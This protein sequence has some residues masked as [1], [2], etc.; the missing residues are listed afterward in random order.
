MDEIFG[1]LHHKGISREGLE[2][3]M[4]SMVVHPDMEA[5]CRLISSRP[6]TDCFVLS[7]SNTVF[8]D[9]IL[10]HYKLAD[11][12]QRVVTNPAEFD[13]QGRLHVQH[14]H[15][16]SCC[17]CPQNLC[18]GHFLDQFRAAKKYDKVV[19]IGDGGGDVCPSLRLSDRD[20]V[21]ARKDF[22]LFRK[23]TSAENLHATL[24]PWASATDVL[25]W[26]KD[27]LS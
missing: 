25:Q 11:I 4:C 12:V 14:C 13:S 19:Y 24:V 26:F 18:K 16:H 2:S 17:M 10:R 22:T 7:D 27:N 8:I 20:T 15:Q 3:H 6:E 21:L 9:T 23:L 5:A 1:E